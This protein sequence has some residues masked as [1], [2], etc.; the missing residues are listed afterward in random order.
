MAAP[1]NKR[2]ETPDGRPMMKMKEL[3]QATGLPKSTIL[4]YLKAGLLPKPFKT[5]PNMAYYDPAAVERLTFIRQAQARHRLPLAIIKNLMQ[6]MERGRDVGPLLE[7]QSFLFGRNDGP[8]LDAAAF[9]K[10]TGLTREQ[11]KKYREVRILLPL[12]DGSYDQEDVA[13]GRILANSPGPGHAAGRLEILRR[14]RG[15]DRQKGTGLAPGI[16]PGPAI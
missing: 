15:R 3:T 4:H 10:A 8:R 14:A 9:M 16:H 7:L 2:P 13:V 12:E 6:E 1:K 11:I 5:G